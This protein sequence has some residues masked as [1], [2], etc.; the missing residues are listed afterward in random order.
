MV[1]GAARGIG[2]TITQALHRVGMSV[3]LV[4]RDA[5]E[6]SIAVTSLAGGSSRVA[7]V[8]GTMSTDECLPAINTELAAMP[9]LG[10]WVNNAGRVSHVAAEDAD[11]AHFEEV[12]RDNASSVLRGSQLAF[13]QMT[14]HGAGGAIVNVGSLVTQKILPERIAY[15]TS[16]AAVANLTRYCAQE[17]GP[18]GI[19]VNAVSPG[20]VDSR[21]TAWA[22]DDPRAVARRAVVDGLPLRR[23]GTSDDVA[24]TVL[25]LASPLAAYVTGETVLLDGG[26]HL[27]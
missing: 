7:S 3:L 26:W 27:S 16:K 1:T 17:W 20:Y 10:V 14:C 6:L 2:L 24:R 5:A 25:Y 22:E 4:D 19:R 13:R 15:A 23:G 11:L 8:A 9:P 18:H 21:L 12:L